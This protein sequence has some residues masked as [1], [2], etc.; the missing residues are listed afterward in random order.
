MCQGLESRV[1]LGVWGSQIRGVLTSCSGVWH[2]Q[3]IYISQN[4][5]NLESYI[6]PQAHLE[7]LQQ[8]LNT[9]EHNYSTYTDSIQHSMLERVKEQQNLL[10]QLLFPYFSTSPNIIITFYTVLSNFATKLRL[11]LNKTLLL[12]PPYFTQINNLYPSMKRTPLLDVKLGDSH[13]VTWHH[14]A[15]H[16]TVLLHNTHH[17][18]RSRDMSTSRRGSI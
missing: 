9:T 6:S 10:G 12:E 1:P 7:A 5:P 14:I 18:Q 4:I 8:Q 3:N 2:H 16:R 11:S 13:T 15:N 17:L